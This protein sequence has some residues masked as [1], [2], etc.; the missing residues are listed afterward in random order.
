MQITETQQSMVTISLPSLL[1]FGLIIAIALIFYGR[2]K[3]KENSGYYTLIGIG[4]SLLGIMVV[5]SPLFWYGYWALTGTSVEMLFSDI[6]ILDFISAIGGILLGYGLMFT[7]KRPEV[8][9]W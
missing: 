8:S 9:S 7:Q 6:L 3:G 2:S 5:I 4:I 1:M